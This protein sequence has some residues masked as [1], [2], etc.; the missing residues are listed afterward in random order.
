MQHIVK[1]NHAEMMQ[2]VV[3]G[4]EQ[5]TP[6]TTCNKRTHVSTMV[7]SPRQRSNQSTAQLR[8]RG[9]PKW[10]YTDCNV[11][12]SKDTVARPCM[13]ANAQRRWQ[14]HWLKVPVV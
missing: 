6:N 11:A 9:E 14:Q 7:T 5:L 2:Q 13:A 10:A 8:S 1:A 3:S 4:F 12:V